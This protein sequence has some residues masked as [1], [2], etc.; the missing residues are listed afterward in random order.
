M[1]CCMADKYGWCKDIKE[2]I[3]G[4]DGKDY[5]I[6]HAP[7]DSKSP[8]DLERETNNIIENTSNLINLSGSIFNCPIRFEIQNNKSLHISNSTFLYRLEIVDSNT[9]RIIAHNSKF[10]TINIF[11]SI[12][13]LFQISKTK[14]EQIFATESTFKYVTISDINKE[15]ETKHNFV[16]FVLSNIYTFSYFN[17]KTNLSIVSCT[18]DKSLYVNDICSNFL[19]IYSCTINGYA[20][21][22]KIETNKITISNTIPINNLEISNTNLSIFPL[23]GS[24]IEN[25]TFTLCEWPKHKDRIT[26]KDSISIIELIHKKQTYSTLTKKEYTEILSTNEDIFRRLK[27]KA[28]L[29]NNEL[30]ASDWHYGEKFMLE[31]RLWTEAPALTWLTL[32][33]YRQISDYGESPAKAL[34]VLLSFLSLFPLTF[35]LFTCDYTF[36]IDSGDIRTLT[37]NMLNYIP[38]ASKAPDSSKLYPLRYLE[39]FW[40]TVITIQAA[41]TGFAFRNKF[42]R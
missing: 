35:S 1:V 15:E 9:D 34:W 20:V 16:E 14:L 4:P 32:W 40:Q 42:R 22:N 31:K 33:L 29:D 41:I 37:N 6:F 25:I 7:A 8:N 24:P 30:L 12:V 23:N 28:R 2:T 3:K 19:Q 39:I 26:T 36:P 5:C 21:L 10:K 11:N 17:S 18:I 13:N 27:K 38:F